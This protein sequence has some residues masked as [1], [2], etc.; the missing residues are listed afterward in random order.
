MTDLLPPSDHGMEAALLGTLMVS[1]PQ[2]LADVYGVERLR[3]ETFDRPAHRHAF[4]AMIDV[5]SNGDEP[6]AVNVR[7]ALKSAPLDDPDKFV[8]SLLAAATMPTDAAGYVRQLKAVATSRGKFTA[9]RDLMN[10]AAVGDKAGIA[11]AEA[12]LAESDDTQQRRKSS[13]ERQQ[14]IRELVAGSTVRWRTGIGPLDQALAGGL[15]PGQYTTL[16]AWPSH[17]KSALVSQLLRFASG[18]GA[19]C[20][21]Y[22]NEMEAWEVDARTIANAADVPYLRLLEGGKALTAEH[23]ASIER[24]IPDLGRDFAL[25]EAAGM[26]AQ[27][28]AYDMQRQRWDVVAL[29]LFNGLPGSNETKEVDGN[30][31]A[32]TTATRLASCHVIGCQ[33]LSEHRHKGLEYPPMPAAS[34]IRQ[35]GQI[36]ARSNNVWFLYLEEDPDNR[37]EP[38]TD[39]KFRV[40]KAR[41]GA[42][43]TFDLEFVPARLRFQ[44]PLPTATAGGLDA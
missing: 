10:A 8:S 21:I 41:G 33:H 25:I 34:D 29:D 20:G 22:T 11:A 40:A 17:G 16:A 19:K 9:A 28:V 32:I 15:R 39:V 27:E 43:G 18:Q 24:A 30:I 2:L 5:A 42:R 26:T 44:S 23:R 4:E 36:F 7:A 6:N 31:A 1:P 38:S 13:A 37:G 12:R 3:P 35:S 14:A